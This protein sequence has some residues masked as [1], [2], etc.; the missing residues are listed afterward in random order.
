M[1]LKTRDAHLPSDCRQIDLDRELPGDDHPGWARLKADLGL[2]GRIATAMADDRED[3]D[4]QEPE[5]W[6]GLG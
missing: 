2:I 4:E 3:D 1:Y 6:D 5:R